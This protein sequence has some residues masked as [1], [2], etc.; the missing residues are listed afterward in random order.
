MNAAQRNHDEVDQD[1]NEV[2]EDGGIPGPASGIAAEVDQ[3]D[4]ILHD[5][6]ED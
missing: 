3:L 1:E 5:N 4:G 2:R 6:E